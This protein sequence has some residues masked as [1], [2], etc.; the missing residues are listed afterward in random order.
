[1]TTPRSSQPA[2]DVAAVESRLAALIRE[3]QA[4]RSD[5]KDSDAQRRKETLVSLGLGALAIIF[6]IIVLGVAIQNRTIANDA[7]HSA[8]NAQATAALIKDCT[9]PSGRCYQDG[10]KRTGGAVGNIIKA[11]VIVAECSRDFPS[12]NAKFESCVATR[13]KTAFPAATPTPAPPRKS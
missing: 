2:V 1:M 9:T 7:K 5:L 8:D 10:S 6:I 4:L 11:Q 3:S 12:N 13:L